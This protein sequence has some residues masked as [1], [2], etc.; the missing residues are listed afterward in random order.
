MATPLETR[1]DQLNE[2]LSTV[3]NKIGRQE[4]SSKAYSNPLAKFKKGFIDHANEIEEIYVQRVA[5]LTQDKA[6]ETTLKRVKPTVKALYH[7]QN[8][9]KCY[10]ATISDKQVR[11][12]FQSQDGV[13]RLSDEILTQQHTGVEYDEY[14]EMKKAI[15][16]FAKAVPSSAKRTIADVIDGAT[17]KDLVKAIKKDIA[18]MQFRSTNYCKYEQHTRA[19]DIVLFLHVD[20]QAEIDV[21]LLATALNMD[22][23]EI[24]SRVFF[25]DGFADA[26]LKAVVMDF[27]AIKVYDTLYSNEAQRNAQGMY[28]NYHLNV[29][30]IISYSTL[31]NGASY[32]TAE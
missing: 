2:F 19:E 1:V 13:K 11:Q 21:E 27:N 24:G 26:K 6:G 3:V 29:E 4:W 7:T 32:S 28:T 10:T 16:S 17:A 14:V 30:K 25:V 31:F 22:K 15:E 12:A 9:G 20:Y 8:F 5:G 18:K 23:A